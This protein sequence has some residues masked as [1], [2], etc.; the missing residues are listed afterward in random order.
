MAMTT[1]TIVKITPLSNNQMIALRQVQ[2]AGYWI[3][4]DVQT[5]QNVDSPA[6][7][8]FL[9]L[10]SGEYVDGAYI[11]VMVTYKL[12]GI[13]IIKKL[14]RTMERE[15]ISTKILV[16]EYIL[17]DPISNPG[18]T[19]V[20][21]DPDTK[22]LSLWITAKSGDVTLGPKKYEATQRMPTS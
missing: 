7:D 17:Y 5:A 3:T 15:G 11:P 6:P 4:R 16:A 20:E 2:N 19:K 12:E 8:E 9:K 18:V 10:T 1:A 14:T 21:Y 13:D 22:K